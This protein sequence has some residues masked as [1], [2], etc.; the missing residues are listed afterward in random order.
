MDDIAPGGFSSVPMLLTPVAG[1][2]FFTA[3]DGF[4][5]REPWSLPL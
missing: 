1:R 4:T 2:L 5:G 3:D